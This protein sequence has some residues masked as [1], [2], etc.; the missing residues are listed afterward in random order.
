MSAG[1]PDLV[2][3]LRV[4]LK[5]RDRLRRENA[6]LL[7]GAGEPIAIVGMACRYPG[8]VDSPRSLWELVAAG[9]DAIGPFPTDR[10]WDL[11][12]LYSP[13]PDRPGTC[14][15]RGGGF[16][17]DVAGFDAAFFGASPREAIGGDPQLR[18]L[19]ETSWEVLED[20]RIVPASLRGSQTGVFVGAM[21]HDYGW[22]RVAS[23]RESEINS[24]N[25]G[26]GSV[27]SGHL[28]YTYGLEGPTVSIDTACSTSLVAMHLAAQALRAGEC[29]LALAGGVTVF[30]TPRSFIESA[31]Q[32]GLAP[33]GR[34]KAFAEAADG[35]GFSEGVGLLALERL[36]DAQRNG[37]HVLATIRGSA[38][39]QDGA[40]N[41]MTAPNGPAQERVIRQALAN[42]RLEP[43]EVDAVEAHGTGTTLG[44]P[45]E[46]GALLATYGQDREVP[47]K[48][49]SV[50]SNIGHPQA[51][52]G[53]AGVI[54]TV[55]AMR[56]GVLPKTL[57]VDAPSSKIDWG[58][59][60]VE[61]LAEASAWE[62]D[63]RPRRAGVSAFGATGTNAHL[64]L[65]QAPPPVADSG[66]EDAPEA[67][68][69]GPVPL[70][71][72]ARSE[73]ALRESAERLA[74]HLRESPELD[75]TDVAHSLTATRTGFEQRAV[76]L[77]AGREQ[78]LGGLAALAGDAGAPGL[79]RGRARADRDPVFVFPGYGSQWLGMGRELIETSPVFARRMRE[80]TEALE[81]HLKW[82]LE[83]ILRG[84][85]GVPSI[86]WPFVGTQALFAVTVSL[87]ELWRACGV[88]PAAVVG[89]SQ[90]ELIAA[91]VAG[92]L[93]L[94]DAARA[95]VARIESM[96]P[97][98]GNGGMASIALPGG[99]IEPRLE[100]WGGRVSIAALNGPSSTVVSGDTEPL[101]ELIA[102]CVA[103]GVKAKKIQGASGASHSAQVEALHDGMIEALAPIAPRSGEVPFHSTVTGEVLDMAELTPEYWYRNLRQTVRLAPVIADLIE[104]GRRA[105]IE[106][107]PHPVLGLS[108]G[109]IAAAAE[110]PDSV[111]VL[112]T[113]RRDDGG[114]ERF[115]TSLA[116]AHAAGAR[117][118]WSRFFAGTGARSVA[119]PTYPFQRKRF[120][121]EPGNGGSDPG[122]IGL[123][124]TGHPLLR[125]SIEDPEGDRVTLSGRVSIQSHPWLADS[126]GDGAAAFP[127]SG[128][129]ELALRAG[130]EVGCERLLELTLEQPLALPPGA[131]VQLQVRLGEPGESG[132]RP[133]SIHA[134]PEGDEAAGWI[135]H[136]SGAVG[137]E[138]ARGLALPA[139]WPPPDAE[140]I[141]VDAT[142]DRL[143]AAGLDYGPAFQGLTAAWAK[144]GEVFAEVSLA[145]EQVSEASRFGLHPALLDS[146]LHCIGAGTGEAD[147]EPPGLPAAWAG[148]SL[149]AGGAAALRARISPSADGGV[150][151][152]LADPQGEPVASVAGLR[153][154]AGLPASPRKAAS[155][156][157]R[158]RAAGAGGA[159]ATRLAAV[160]E[161]ERES[162]V[163]DL[164]RG[165]AALVLGHDSIA[166]VDPELPFRD[167]GFD[168][169]GAVELRNRL[170]AATGI[171][172][173]PTLVFDYPSAAELARYLLEQASGEGERARPVLRAQSSDEPIAIVGIACRYP[174]SAGSPEQLWE[175][176]AA[177]RDAI[178]PFP[179]DRGWDLERL[180][181]P[182]PD[183]PGRATPARAASSTTPPSSTRP[184]SASR[185]A[186]RPRSTP[187]SGCSWNPP[188]RRSSTP[189]STPSPCAAPR[190][191]SSPA[192]ARSTTPAGCSTPIR[193]STAS[194]SSAPPAAW[195]RE[196][197]LHPRP[198]GP[199]DDRRHRLLLLAGR[200]PPRRGGA[201]GGGVRAGPGRRRLRALLAD[202]LQ[203][204]QPPAR[205]GARRALQ[206]L[207]RGRR[208]GRLV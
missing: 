205:P 135:C 201:A 151:L 17:D 152:A 96:H 143:A 176:L 140:P 46:A 169:A 77:G 160:A 37:R 154:R 149:H 128:L 50:K 164:V 166:E 35:V 25:V 3:A 70:V 33:D 124:D 168:S 52:A 101:E 133:L 2:E 7:D 156:P 63:G 38:V 184:S 15:A 118:E 59:G 194:A 111:A 202:R 57:H 71:L 89:H 177:G 29:S 47:L 198:R 24:P 85:E 10:G 103:A 150:A 131:G 95:V 79:I 183:R 114:P 39:N 34:S 185:R 19:V 113:L 172:L 98:D 104:Q 110:G 107:S 62:S 112:G 97:L 21:F 167:L 148:V 193:R 178:G 100:R 195:S 159:L 80:C 134:R 141:D 108:L 27:L 31:R 173:S 127:A 206:G 188:G 14:Y 16:L 60:K 18:L 36:S 126:A 6:R 40:S 22:G 1:N 203:R 74:S 56:E 75:L 81:P 182:D 192:S 87:V 42:A 121:L 137:S 115:A 53:V 129:L 171:S 48:L 93:N 208:R 12:R 180:H 187:S 125:A 142:Y 65:E 130:A 69:S 99:E 191:G 197:L 44:D 26:A 58:A 8:G 13:D 84:A 28:A 64:I 123:G 55:M 136:A 43:A 88:E 204:V 11:E 146:V 23:D 175:M 68:L 196:G 158:R 120:W 105:F 181:H 94:D 73:P 61:L 109:E 145:P 162:L 4:A 179:A 147:V 76:V 82:P 45:I 200:D 86:D 49:G 207:L 102:E 122:A 170:G 132:A 20:A 144:D 30:S 66:G 138:V 153:L 199:V 163:L 190:P 9:G 90:G 161:E 91:H 83:D 106:V 119:L 116:E 117:V 155:A 51:A 5:E 72:S 92:G 139:A 32:R 157:R 189:A 165:E 186:K 174:G 67:A 41:G 78:L 54:K